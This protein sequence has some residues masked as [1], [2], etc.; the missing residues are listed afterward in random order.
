MQALMELQIAVQQH[1]PSLSVAAF[2]E[3]CPILLERLLPP[4]GLSIKVILQDL[5]ED[6]KATNQLTILV[7][8]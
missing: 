4:K 5:S 2:S 8:G 7:M 1:C 6:E 3:L